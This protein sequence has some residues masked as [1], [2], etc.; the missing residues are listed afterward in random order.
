MELAFFLEIVV[1]PLVE[2]T[3]TETRLQFLQKL[4]KFEES[5]QVLPEIGN[6]YEHVL[7]RVPQLQE[8]VQAPPREAVPEAA[9][10]EGVL[11]PSYDADIALGMQLDDIIEISD[12]EPNIPNLD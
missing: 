11:D 12:D 4:R 2:A 6:L 7:E 5:R 1:C 3:D 9:P 8:L 10:G